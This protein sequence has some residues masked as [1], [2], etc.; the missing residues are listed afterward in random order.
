[1]DNLPFSVPLR[2]ARL[3]FKRHLPPMSERAQ[4]LVRVV[5]AND[6][7][8]T[9][10]VDFGPESLPPVRTADL[11]HAWEAARQAASG[12][13]WGLPRAFRFLQEDG[14]TLDLALSDEDACCWAAAVDQTTGMQTT[15]GLSLCLRLLALVDLLARAPWTGA[16]CRIA[17]AGATL[18]PVLVRTAATSPL[19]NGAD[20]DESLF[21]LKLG[22]RAAALTASGAPA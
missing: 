1:M 10:L 8:V 13:E 14:T 15:Y 9:Y 18:D 7:S 5:Q 3:A 4:S 17:R 22:R 20:F 6:G 16:H 11:A 12:A 19:T 2:L 21:R